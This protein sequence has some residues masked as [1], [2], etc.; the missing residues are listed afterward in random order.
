MPSG[1]GCELPALRTRV[2]DLLKLEGSGE[3]FGDS[4][5]EVGEGEGS[6][7]VPEREEVAFQSADQG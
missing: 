3:A 6:T 1:S 7:T 2:S 4:I 5:D